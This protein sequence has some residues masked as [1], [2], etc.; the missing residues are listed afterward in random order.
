MF[1]LVPAIFA[2]FY[3]PA[4]FINYGNAAEAARNIMAHERPF[5]LGLA[6]DLAVFAADIALT[7]AGS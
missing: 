7:T 1:A 4:Q 3:I 6:S 5:R 2:E